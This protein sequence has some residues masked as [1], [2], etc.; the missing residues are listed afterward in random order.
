MEK[1]DSEVINCPDPVSLIEPASQEVTNGG[2]DSA[3]PG[4]SNYQGLKE[5]EPT[6]WKKIIDDILLV[7]PGSINHD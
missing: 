3:Q 7:C 5:K 2:A 6:T 1:K 4:N